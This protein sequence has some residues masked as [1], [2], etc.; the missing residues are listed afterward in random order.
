M[1][2]CPHCQTLREETE[3]SCLNDGTL[4]DSVRL[5]RPD[6][7]MA[8]RPPEPRLTIY[9]RLVEERQWVY[10]RS[11]LPWPWYIPAVILLAAALQWLVPRAIARPIV[12]LYVGG[13]L[14]AL[15]L[16]LGLLRRYRR[17]WSDRA[18]RAIAEP[19][20]ALLAPLLPRICLRRRLYV[21]MRAE[22]RLIGVEIDQVGTWP[23]RAG[24][25]TL[26]FTGRWL[27]H[28]HLF[29]AT[30]ISLASA[31]DSGLTVTA[32][33]EPETLLAPALATTA[34]YLIAAAVWR[35]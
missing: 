19:F 1:W 17:S 27:R 9:G 11:I 28:G 7:G 22:N 18:G 24:R 25:A 20:V 16:V 34:I 3:T 2:W 12:L 4:R 21:Q 14:F 8:P 5:T 10:E 23:F 6:R 30:Q 31:D 15:L 13:G 33:A 29:R 26:R 32:A 35:L